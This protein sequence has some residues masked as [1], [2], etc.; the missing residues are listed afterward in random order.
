MKK[1]IR[2]DGRSSDLDCRWFT[3]SYGEHWDKW[4]SYASQW[5]KQQEKALNSHRNAITWFLES[6]LIE[7]NLPSHPDELLLNQSNLPDSYQTLLKKMTP[8]G[9]AA[10]NNKVVRFIDW[11]ISKD[12]SEPND[13][14]IPV[15]Q[16]RN[17]FSFVQSKTNAVETIRSPLPYRYIRE[18]RKIICPNPRGNFKEWAWAQCQ[19]GQERSNGWN[20]NLLGDWFEVEPSLIDETDPDCVW[21]KRTYQGRKPT[22]KNGKKELIERYEMWSP[23]RAIVIYTKLQLPLRTYQ[24]RLLDSGESDTLRYHHGEW[25]KNNVHD[26]L[27]NQSPKQKGVFRRIVSYETGDVMTG[28]YVSTNKTA[29]QNKDDIDRGY[30]IPWQHEDVLYWLEL[31]RK[32]QPHK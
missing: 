6:Y 12:Y 30:V 15:P 27:V 5:L 2:Y 32:V 8:E 26:A 22:Q 21:R 31:A 14:N 20:A 29:D 18:L 1:K 3:E 16:V 17:P 7:F 11:I 13:H 23:V 10:R 24:V 19:S 9:A 28:I 25:A 4:R